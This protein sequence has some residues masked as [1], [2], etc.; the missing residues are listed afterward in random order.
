MLFVRPF[1][2]TTPSN[3]INLF[4]NSLWNVCEMSNDYIMQYKENIAHNFHSQ[5]INEFYNLNEL[6]QESY[7]AMLVLCVFFFLTQQRRRKRW[8][9]VVA[10]ILFKNIQIHTSLYTLFYSDEV[11]FC[12]SNCQLFQI[13]QFYC[14]QC[15][16]SVQLSA[17]HFPFLSS[18]FNFPHYI[19]GYRINGCLILRNYEQRQT[20]EKTKFLVNYDWVAR[21]E[22]DCWNARFELT[23]LWLHVSV[24]VCVGHCKINRIYR[25]KIKIIAL[26][27]SYTG[28]V[29]IYDSIAFSLTWYCMFPSAFNCAARQFNAN[30]QQSVES[31]AKSISSLHSIKFCVWLL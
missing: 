2:W 20:K 30:T 23:S 22:N 7:V 8:R 29:L 21:N 19:I 1:H 28:S 13:K 12:T 24:C 5:E 17:D 18:S 27:A 3:L 16:Y 26:W 10:V 25:E 11:Y 4:A 31:H 15:A 9:L 6:H 14:V